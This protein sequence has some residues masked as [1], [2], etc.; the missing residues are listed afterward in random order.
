MSKPVPYEWFHCVVDRLTHPV[1]LLGRDSQL[2][3]GNAA[4]YRVL[5]RGWVGSKLTERVV[6][7]ETLLRYLR[8]SSRSVEPLPG[9]F[10]LRDQRERWRFDVCAVSVEGAMHWVL[11]LRPNSDMPGRFLALNT[12]IEK[13]QV[14]IRRRSELE[15]ERELLLE[16]E[17]TARAE[18]ESANRLKDEFLTS[19]SHE[20]RTPLHAISGWVQILKDK[21][22]DAALRKQALDVIE[23]NI[24]VQTQLTEDLVDTA[25]LTTGRLKLELAHVDLGQVIRQAVDIVLPEARA[26]EQRIEAIVDVGSC[27]INADWNRMVQVFC[28]LLTNASRYT[29]NGGKIQ[30]VV[31][32]VNSHVEVAVSDTGEGIASELLPYVFD[33]FRRN[34]VTSTRRRGGL[35]LGLSIVRHLVE[36][37]G[38]VVMVDSDGLGQGTTFTVSLPLPLFRTPSVA[39]AHQPERERE[40][41]LAGVQVLL[42]E[43][44][45]DSR[46]LLDAILRS[47]G[48]QVIAVCSSALAIEAFH[49]HPPDIVVSDIEMPDEDGFTMIRK[50]RDIERQLERRPVPAIA[51]SAHAPGEV[52]LHALRAGYQSF[53][54]K[55]IRVSELEAT[56]LS[57][58]HN[59]Q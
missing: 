31:R 40:V 41:P 10:V 39:I 19:V 21:A 13:L 3:T 46:D 55:P 33:R 30:V 25:L 27:H 56:V 5:D 12:Q 48:A 50:M 43:D 4:V 58:R 32:R 23:R 35:G 34:D 17:R 51:V 36:L 8:L 16:A 42:V 59:A 6:N 11:C 28:N 15:Q 18:A 7:P 38:G 2:L 1:A 57:L 49:K 47:R 9:A 53:L 26:K 52:R 45:N 22:D 20:L 24:L 54:A 29:P 14:E 44:H 37:H